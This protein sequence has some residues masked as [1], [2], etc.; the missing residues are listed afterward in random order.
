M[1]TFDHFD[2][3]IDR[4]AIYPDGESARTAGLPMPQPI[5]DVHVG[6]DGRVTRESVLF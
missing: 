3:F 2:H 4:R 6:A 5:S 1:S